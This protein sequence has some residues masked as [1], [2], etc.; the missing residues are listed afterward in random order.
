MSN[1]TPKGFPWAG[2]ILTMMPLLLLGYSLV[3]KIQKD[4][5]SNTDYNILFACIGYLAGTMAMGS[6][7][8][9][10]DGSSRGEEG[11]GHPRC[12]NRKKADP[13]DAADGE[14]VE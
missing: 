1:Y 8:F 13:T 3:F 7:W 4:N 9:F 2:F 11:C 12:P 6:T 14:D 5:I 10:K